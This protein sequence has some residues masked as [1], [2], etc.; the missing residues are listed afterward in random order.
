MSRDHDKHH[1]R[2]TRQNKPEPQRREHMSEFAKQDF[3][4]PKPPKREYA[5]DPV[6]GKP[7]ENIFLAFDHRDAHVPINF[8]TALEQVKATEHLGPGEFVCY[9]GQ[10]NFAV[11]HEREENGRKILEQ[12][13]KIPFEDHHEK[14][15]WRRELSPGISKDY[16]PQ[17]KVLSELYTPE[18]LHAFPRLGTGSG[19]YLPRNS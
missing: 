4:P 17:P 9:I 14:P 11:Y 15:Q 19:I 18:E 10:G 8:D 2:R 5:P 3:T 12:R 7:I 6:N 13:K 1:N 16:L